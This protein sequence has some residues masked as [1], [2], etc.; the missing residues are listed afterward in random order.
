M[1]KNK[2]KAKKQQQKKALEEEK[3]EEEA[4]ERTAKEQAEDD[5]N[6]QQ[7]AQQQ[8]QESSVTV[9]GEESESDE[10]DGE[11]QGK[12]EPGEQE[13]GE[14]SAKQG[15][16]EDKQ[17]QNESQ[18]KPKPTSKSSTIKGFRSMLSSVSRAFSYVLLCGCVFCLNLPLFQSTHPLT[19][20]H[21]HI[22]IVCPGHVQIGRVSRK[23]CGFQ[24]QR[25]W[26]TGAKAVFQKTS[27]KGS[28]GRRH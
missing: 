11:P 19:Y 25:W 27:W 6:P 23:G 17:G 10:E 24:R 21:A 18:D 13:S 2:K 12:Q 4:P 16:E 22:F 9:A 15:Q 26:T 20:A 1:G 5:D 14:Q 8:Q 28:S 3:Q 7:Q